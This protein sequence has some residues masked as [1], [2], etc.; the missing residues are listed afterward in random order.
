[1]L[2]NGDVL[3]DILN[4]C[5]TIDSYA[6][7]IYSKLEKI[8]YEKNELDLSMFWGEMATEEELHVNF[9]ENINNLARKGLIPQLFNQPYSVRAE[10]E[11]AK[12]SVIEMEESCL[13]EKGLA[14][15][16][17]LIAYRLEFY[18]LHPAFEVFFQFLKTIETSIQLVNPDEDYENHI[19]K[20]IAALTKFGK[21]SPEMDLVGETLIRL[22]KENRKLAK[23]G[24]SDPLTG[25]L[26]RRGFFQ[27]LK[28]YLHFAQRNDH[29]IGVLMIDIDNFKIINDF[30]GHQKG[31]RVLSDVSRQIRSS[32]RKSDLC[33]RYGGEEFIVVLHDT[34]VSA[35]QKVG[36]LIRRAVEAARPD[37]ILVTVSI[38]G[39]A[40]KIDKNIETS[41]EFYINRADKRM[42]R[43]KKNGRNR[44]I[45]D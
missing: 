14:N 21:V 40:G 12:Q 3:N 17:F 36:E 26:N 44:L 5:F 18:L 28:P 29:T 8:F 42:Y 16:G 33:A 11:H 34:D 13:S 24:N 35:L 39:A 9:W 45:T 1:M 19:N 20:F 37:D 2:S 27:T 23:L 6:F 41:L 15:N 4:L 43:A 10:L 25:L 7:K 31:D 38:G 22:W 30:H 32:V